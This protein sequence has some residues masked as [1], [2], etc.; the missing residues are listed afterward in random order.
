[1]IRTYAAIAAAFVVALLGGLLYLVLTGENDDRYAQCRETQVAGGAA[2]IGGPFTL[3]DGHGRSVTESDVLAKPALVYFGY[4]FCPDVCP[5]DM[6]RNSEAV[7]LLEAQGTEV[8]P[9]FISVDP[10]RDTPDAVLDWTAAM[11]P[12]AIGLTGSPEQ[13]R[14]AARAYKVYFS[15][16]QNPADEYYT[17]DHST[18]TYLMLPGEGFAEFY[19]RETTPEDMARS[20]ACYVGAS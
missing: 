4:T 8:A 11:H 1:M 20:V 6:V 7:D 2:A 19:R 14:E 3:V 17:V 18:F 10:A 12:R 5:F 9:V 16:P 13:I 15:V